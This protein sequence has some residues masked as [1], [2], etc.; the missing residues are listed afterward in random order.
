[1]SMFNTPDMGAVLERLARLLA[2]G[3]LAPEIARSYDLEDAAEAQRAVVED[4]FVGKLVV[5][6]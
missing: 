1:M 6:P 5:E 2:D 3:E 4:S